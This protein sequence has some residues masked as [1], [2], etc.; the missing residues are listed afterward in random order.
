VDSG[1]NRRVVNIASVSGGSITN[2]FVACYSDYWTTDIQ[3]FKRIAGEMA[4]RIAFKGMWRSPFVWLYIFVLGALLLTFVMI[5]TGA[6]LNHSALSLPVGVSLLALA[7]VLLYFRGA[8][9]AWWMEWT[10]FRRPRMDAEH[11]AADTSGTSRARSEPAERP[12]FWWRIALGGLPRRTVDH[13]FCATDLNHSLPIFFSTRG[14]GRVLTRAYGMA[15]LPSLSVARAVRASAA[16]PPAFPPVRLR[17]PREWELAPLSQEFDAS[18]QPRSVWLTDGGPYNNLATDWSGLRHRIRDLT[19]WSKPS[20]GDNA[21]FPRRSRF[22]AI[23]LVIDASQRAPRAQ[24]WRLHLPVFAIVAYLVRVM[25]VMYGSTVSART[26]DAVD[27][28]KEQMIT[29]PYTWKLVDEVGL[30]RTTSIRPL[31][32][33]ASYTSLPTELAHEW[34][35]FRIGGHDFDR[36]EEYAPDMQEAKGILGKLWPDGR[37]VPTTLRSLGAETTLRLIVHGYLMTR[38]VLTVSLKQHQRPCVPGASWFEE[39]LI[40]HRRVGQSEQ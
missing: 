38:E 16:L 26:E 4:R 15:A 9:V 20:E 1:L 25:N 5:V 24:L 30:D 36:E 17:L 31:K 8:P 6:I 34:G 19:D 29:N 18:T 23:Q 7:F 40:P 11:S 28:A 37:R 35:K 21:R 13:V 10:F 14:G 27:I 32:L 33:V 2:G 3:E 22:G 12:F 39:L